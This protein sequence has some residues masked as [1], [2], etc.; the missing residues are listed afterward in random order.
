MPHKLAQRAALD[1]LQPARQTV[2]TKMGL[3]KHLRV[4]LLFAVYLCFN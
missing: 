4:L 1:T 3:V 2:M